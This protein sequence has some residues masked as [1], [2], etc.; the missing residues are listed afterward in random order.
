MEGLTPSAAGPVHALLGGRVRLQQPAEGLRAGMDA[1]MLAASVEMRPGGVVLDAGCGPGGVF[2][3]VLARIPGARAVAV[4]RDPVLAA[5][6]R[7]NAALNGWA[8]RV[9]VVEADVSDPA[10]RARLPRADA[11]VSNPP[12]WPGGSVPPVAIRAGATHAGGVGLRDWAALLGASLARGGR[13]TIV[14]PAGRLEDGIGALRGAGL[15]GTEILPLWPRSGDAAG[16]VLL[17]ARR[18]PR[19]PATLLPG[20]VLHEGAGWTPEAEAVLRGGAL[21]WSPGG[22]LAP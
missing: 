8:D 15:G 16:R 21:G 6:A 1:V 10:L 3:C 7:E 18:A 4:E 13:A 14:L 9:E 17:R 12:Y 20:L 19:A 5:L 11:A 22:K 2:L